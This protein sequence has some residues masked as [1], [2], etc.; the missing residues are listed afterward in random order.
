MHTVRI[1]PTQRQNRDLP[2]GSKKKQSSQRMREQVARPPAGQVSINQNER[3]NRIF[4][5]IHRRPS[6][7]RPGDL[8]EPNRLH[9]Y[10]A[11]SKRKQSSQRMRE[12]PAR[13]P[14]G[15]SLLT[16]TNVTTA[17]SKRYTVARPSPAPETC[18]N[19]V[20]CRQMRQVPGA[21]RPP[22]YHR[23]NFTQI[24]SKQ[25]NN[26]DLPCGSK[27][28]QSSQRM[29]EQLARPPQGRSLLAKTPI[30]S[31]SLSKRT[32]QLTIPRPG[33]L[34]EPIQLTTVAAGPPGIPPTRQSHHAHR[35]D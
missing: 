1:K 11:G 19:Q 31:G 27:R 2:C 34:P 35:S 17:S 26:R 7:P 24:K 16:K 25:H 18:P 28:K 29:I 33:D 6:I 20:N 5:T 22:I 4:Q 14:Q 12:Q 21:I 3:H 15:R 9:P 10:A 23:L 30:T 32:A 13:P 8:P